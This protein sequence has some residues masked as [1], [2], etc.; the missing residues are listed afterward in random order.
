MNLS[1]DLI[2]DLSLDK[3]CL[4]DWT[5]QSTSLFCVV[6]GN[7]STDIECIKNVLSNLSTQYRGVFYIDG[8]LEH[9]NSDLYQDRIDELL[10]MCKNMQ[11]VIYLHNHVV[12]L[13][14]VAFVGING[15]DLDNNHIIDNQY[16]L[17][18][19]DNVRD[20]DFAYLCNTVRMLQQ[21]HDVKK[22]VIIS[23]S[24]PGSNLVFN[25]DHF[26]DSNDLSTALILDIFRKVSHWLYGNTDINVDI[27]NNGIRYTN[28]VMYDQRPYYPKRIDI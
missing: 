3:G 11:N 1:V 20:M 12:V 2:S 4:F 9:S 18:E 7:I 8:I 24:P 5:G 13:E 17:S 22:I 14:G 10:M 27:V 28:N 23:N 6:A 26:S 21:N 16:N 15:W 25:N 19:L